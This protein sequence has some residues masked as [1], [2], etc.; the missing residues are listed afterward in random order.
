MPSEPPGKPPLTGKTGQ[1][2]ASSLPIKSSDTTLFGVFFFPSKFNFIVRLWVWG[3]CRKEKENYP[4]F[5]HPKVFL[6]LS[7]KESSCQC[8]RQGFD[9]G[10][11]HM[12]MGQLSP[13]TT[14]EPILQ[15][16]G[17]TLTKPQCATLLLKPMHSRADAPQREKPKHGS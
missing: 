11:F 9:P 16:P 14:T 12:P 1:Q 8:K 10:R 13:C 17:N 7:G 6:W 2:K 15:S 4:S 3:D 5:Y